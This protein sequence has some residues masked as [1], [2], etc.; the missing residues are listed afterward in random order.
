MQTWLLSGGYTWKH[1]I[2]FSLSFKTNKVSFKR[3]TTVFSWTGSSL[4]VFFFF[5]CFF[6]ASS[7]GRKTCPTTSLSSHCQQVHTQ[8][9]GRPS[10]T[11]LLPTL[12]ETAEQTSTMSAFVWIGSIL[13]IYLYADD[14]RLWFYAVV[15]KKITTFEVRFVRSYLSKLE[16]ANVR[17]KIKR[18][19]SS[20][21]YNKNS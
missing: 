8:H 5:F 4:L 15:G 17:H 13:N 11:S 1:T 6:S 16:K 7:P 21:N 14:N 10:Y 2:C 19:W 3:R 18:F 12:W 9:T 20:L